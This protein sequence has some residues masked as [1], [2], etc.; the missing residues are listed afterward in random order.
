MYWTLDYQQLCEIIHDVFGD[1][2]LDKNFGTVRI[3][4]PW[5]NDITVFVSVTDDK[6]L[7]DKRDRQLVQE[8]AN[9]GAWPTIDQ[10]L[11]ELAFRNEIPA[12]EYVIFVSW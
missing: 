7:H 1:G 4:E 5:N 10:V 12:G 3:G 11:N 8:Y 6:I 2:V 9:G